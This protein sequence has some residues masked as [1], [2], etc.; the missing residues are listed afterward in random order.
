MIAEMLMQSVNAVNN[1]GALYQSFEI[2][3]QGFEMTMVVK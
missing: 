1:A 3:P 2:N